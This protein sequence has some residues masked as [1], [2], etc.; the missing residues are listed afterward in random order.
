MTMTLGTSYDKALYV[1]TPRHMMPE[2]GGSPKGQKSGCFLDARRR[3]ILYWL[4]VDGF[5]LVT[6]LSKECSCT[7][8]CSCSDLRALAH[9][10]SHL[11]P[12]V[13]FLVPAPLLMAFLPFFPV[14]RTTDGGRDH[15]DAKKKCPVSDKERKN[16]E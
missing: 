13:F 1:Q 4:K 12:L 6:V 11:L 7:L 15:G 2:K 8:R 3:S 10:S 14:A 9:A 16:H 5:H